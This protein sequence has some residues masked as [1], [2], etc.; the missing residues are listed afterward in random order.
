MELLLVL[1]YVSICIVIFKIFRIPVNQWSLATATLGGILG[2]LAAVDHELQSSFHGK[3]TDLFCGDAHPAV[4]QRPRD[5]CAGA[6]EHA[7][8]RRR[9]PV[10][11][12]SGTLPVRRRSKASR[13]RGSRPERETAQGHARPGDRGRG[14][15]RS[16]VP[17]GA[18]DPIAKPSF[19]KGGGRTGYARHFRAIS[20]RRGSLSRRPRRGGARP[21]RLRVEHR[22]RQPRGGATEPPN[23]GMPSSTSNR[24]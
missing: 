7:A 18:A 14:K 17:A 16:A 8:Q 11:D 4:G 5:R 20:K 19:R 23:W 1:I 3:R 13:T 21:A 22:R 6:G 15:G 12:R 2:I 9:R 24:P 10:P